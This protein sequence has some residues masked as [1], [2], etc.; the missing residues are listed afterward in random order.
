MLDM[1]GVNALT[2]IIRQQ[3][4][5]SS[6]YSYVVNLKGADSEDFAKHYTTSE[7]INRLMEDDVTYIGWCSEDNKADSQTFLNAMGEGKLVQVIGSDT[8]SYQKQIAEIAYYII[9]HKSVSKY[10]SKSTL[11]KND[12]PTMA[13]LQYYYLLSDNWD[14]YGRD[15][16]NIA[17]DY[18]WTISKAP[19]A[20]DTLSPDKETVVN[21]ENKSI[22][23]E[24]GNLNREFFEEQGAGYYQ[25]YRSTEFE[26]FAEN[27]P[28]YMHLRINIVVN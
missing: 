20:F 6:Y 10:A 17:T 5:D 16:T 9:N 12:G 7:I 25:I 15:G 27:P 3:M 14:I 23:L 19:D 18:G 22:I 4:G 1:D 21:A 13:L 26:E 11:S 24:N 2:E 28:V 8:T